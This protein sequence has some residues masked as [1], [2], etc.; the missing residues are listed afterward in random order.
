MRKAIITAALSAVG[1]ALFWLVIRYVGVENILSAFKSFSPAYM[2][3]FLLIPLLINC[4]STYRWQLIVSEMGYQVPFYKLF[5]YKLMS[6]SL[7]YFSPAPNFSGEP[8][9]AYLLRKYK[10]RMSKALSSVLI[11]KSIEITIDT[12]ISCFIATVMIIFM[13]FPTVIKQIFILSVVGFFLTVGLLYFAIVNHIG[14]VSSISE[15]LSK[16]TRFRIFN[17]I[18]VKSKKVEYYLTT[19]MHFRRKY[20][21]KVLFVTL[22]I[23]P[24]MFLQFKIGLLMLGFKGSLFH[25][26]LIMIFFAIASFFPI[27]ASIGSLEAGQIAAFKL[28]GASPQLGLAMAILIRARDLLWAFVGLVLLWGRGIRNAGRIINDHIENGQDNTHK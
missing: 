25:I 27:P 13:D 7:G 22:L 28:A 10:M 3:L 15:K 24:L 2:L 5:A 26:L 16:L 17:Y 11:D 18:T 8:L 1:V 20:M 23:W 4:I 6:F 21:I 12:M 19:F 9:R 14:L